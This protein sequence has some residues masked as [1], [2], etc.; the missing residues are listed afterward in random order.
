LLVSLAQRERLGGLDE[1][2]AAVGV[3]V[4]I[5]VVALGLSQT[6]FRHDR[7]IV[8]GL[9]G[10]AR[11]FPNQDQ[12]DPHQGRRPPALNMGAGAS[13][14]RAG[15]SAADGKFGRRGWPITGAKIA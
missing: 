14:K 2:A 6:P 11:H 3:F 12:P 9:Y 4:E 8:T 1:T 13:E 10:S 15:A 7:N 5:H